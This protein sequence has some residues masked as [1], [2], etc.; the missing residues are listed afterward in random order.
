M[1]TSATE[2]YLV[3]EVMT[4]TPQKLQLMLIEAAIR[5]AERA[6]LHWKAGEV[7][8]GGECLVRSQ[9]IVGEML[10]SLDYEA[11]SSLVKQVA[12]VYLFI[13]QSLTEAAFGNN[14]QKLDDAIRVMNVERETWR[15]VCDKFGS[16]VSTNNAEYIASTEDKQSPIPAF[17]ASNDYPTPGFSLEA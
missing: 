17:D 13:F 12:G 7:G 9:Q 1:N 11:D 5:A 14:E 8:P 3:T 15:Q 16:D 2:S 4:A 10:S 6:K